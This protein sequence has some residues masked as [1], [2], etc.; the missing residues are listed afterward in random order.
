MLLGKSKLDIIKVL[1]CKS[2]TH[3]YFRHDE[4]FSLNNVLREYNETKEKINNPENF[5]GIHY[6]SM[7]DMS[8]KTYEK[9]VSKTLLGTDKI[10]W[11][12]EKHIDHRRIR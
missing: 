6:K 7:V 5:W 1:I 9:N 12:N 8:R 2:L 3:S 4:L 11:L 10:F